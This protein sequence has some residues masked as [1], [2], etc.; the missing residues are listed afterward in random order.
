M[1]HFSKLALAS[2]LGMMAESDLPKPAKPKT[3]IVTPAIP[4]TAEQ[5]AGHKVD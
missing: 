5:R 3:V 2:Q 1:N 4:N